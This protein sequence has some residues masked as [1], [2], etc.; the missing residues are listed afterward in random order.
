[1]NVLRLVYHLLEKQGDFR[2]DVLE[3]HKTLLA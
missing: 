2:F 3:C 1:M